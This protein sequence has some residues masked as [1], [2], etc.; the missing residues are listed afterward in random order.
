[1][2]KNYKCTDCGKDAEVAY[3]AKSKKDWNGLIKKGERL[4]VNCGRKRLKEMA[5][6]QMNRK[7]RRQNK[8]YERYI[9]TDR[10]NRI[11]RGWTKSSKQKK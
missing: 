4:C 11:H 1:M 8:K 9:G 6:F 2:N 5:F 10:E 3:I 7:Q